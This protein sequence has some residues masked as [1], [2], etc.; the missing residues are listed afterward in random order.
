MIYD[1]IIIGAGAAGLYAGASLPC[2]KNGLIL[3]KSASPGKKLLLSGAGQ[4]NLTHGGSIKDFISHYGLNGNR[5]RTILYRCSNQSVIDFFTE[6][7]ISL[8]EREDGK[9][10]PKSLRATD[11]LDCLTEQCRKNGLELRCSSAVNRI[12]YH[13]ESDDT[14]VLYTIVSGTSHLQTKKIIIATGG[15][16][17]PITGS[18]G[19]LFPMLQAL[20]LS[21]NPLKP[22][23]APL[24]VEEYP[25]NDLS[26]ISFQ[27]AAVSL[28]AAGKQIA[29]N[30][31]PLLFTHNSFS[32]PG[33][34]NL[35]RYVTS[36]MQLSVCYYPG[37]SE[38]VVLKELSSALSSSSK[39][40][41]TEIYEYFNRNRSKEQTDL[42]MPKRFLEV[43]CKRIGIDPA[44]KAAAIGKNQL[45]SI[46]KLIL[47]DKFVLSK[48]GDFNTAMVTAGGILLDEINT[49]TMESK[50]YPGMYFAGEVLDIDGDTGGYNLQFAFSSGWLAANSAF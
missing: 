7:G 5:V 37:R 47:Q 12:I 25:Y 24:F 31:G 20:G 13:P 23:L 27:N 1:L 32:G 28:F 11:I 16:S 49:K 6:C 36:G 9:I 35:S 10:F 21:L 46:V 3:E 18:D 38:D 34:L 19:S 30:C 48:T 41:L 22:A 40:F 44:A 42:E 8:F 26:G 33:I 4:C 29:E 43:L 2:K 15:C 17:Y 50:R 39:Q 45:R 14:G